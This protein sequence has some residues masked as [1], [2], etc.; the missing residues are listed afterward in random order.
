MLQE[1]GTVYLPSL[2]ARRG[3][4]RRSI[5]DWSTGNIRDS[6]WFDLGFV[7]MGHLGLLD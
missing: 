7:W 4:L 1:R 5:R 2:E 3:E 6:D